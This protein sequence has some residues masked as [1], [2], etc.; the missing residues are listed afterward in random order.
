EDGPSNGAFRI[1]RNPISSDPLLVHLEIGGTAQ[2]GEDYQA[3]ASEVTIP[4][5]SASALVS[6]QPLPDESPEQGETVALSLAPDNAYGIGSPA[7]AS[8]IIQ[9]YEPPNTRPTI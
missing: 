8:L 6:I 2:N 3:V 5:N 9:D 1:T 7:S 4:A